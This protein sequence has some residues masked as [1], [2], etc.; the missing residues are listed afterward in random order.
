MCII[1][2]VNALNEVFN[3]DSV[4]HLEFKPVRDWII[5]G[6]GKVLYGGTKYRD[7]LMRTKE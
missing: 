4:N 7:E 3:T 6:K 5:E 1:I 2:D